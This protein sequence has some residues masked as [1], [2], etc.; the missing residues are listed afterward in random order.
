MTSI[1]FSPEIL[2]LIMLVGLVV[3]IFWGFPIGFVMLGI[4]LIVGLLGA[5]PTIF[6]MMVLRTYGTMTEYILAAI[7]LFIFMGVMLELS[8]SAE[9]LFSGVQICL[10]P[11]RGSLIHT[12]IIICTIMAMCTGI[13]GSTVTV[14]GIFA[15]PAMLKR[16][17]DTALSCGSICA[18]G[19]LGILIPPSIML[20]LYA[21]MA[22]ISV[23][24][25][26][27]GAFIPGF[28]LAALFIAYVTLR[29]ALNPELGPPLP[30]AERSMPLG[31]KISMVLT[32]LVPPIF[33]IL[34]CLGSIFFGIASVTEAA[35]AGAVASL[36]LTAFYGKM[37]W[38]TLKMAA[39][40]T[41]KVT[42]MIQLITFSAFVFT[43]S[44]MMI[45]G[46]D[47]T[48]KF[49][50]GLPVSKEAMLFLMLF[51]YFFLGFFM[52]WIGIIPILVPLFTPVVKALGFD[53]IWFGI[54]A[55]VT[56]QTSFLTPPMAPSLFYMKAVAPPEVDFVLHII[57]G[58]IPFIVLQLIG[59]FIIVIFP[60][61]VTWLPNYLFVK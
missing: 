29:C 44:F 32:S 10:G 37:N 42:A 61:F 25:L 50:L 8:G 31:Q 2:T 16:G 6:D 60:G 12:V 53:P 57:R 7:P 22:G 18:G 55:C 54:C 27:A 39:Y 28:I 5:G 56:M 34:A 9:R 59:L 23:I 14:M 33:L 3:G 17:Y 11:L 49:L 36:V 21:P 47:I 38:A 45:G 19:T 58:V 1:I 30:L 26:L 15:L 4:A 20:V 35:A 40:R 46:K 51:A 43:G 48:T 24:H 41:L 52:E 13:V